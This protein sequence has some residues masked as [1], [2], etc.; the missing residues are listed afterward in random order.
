MNL[1]RKP[2]NVKFSLE[3]KQLINLPSN[4][5]KFSK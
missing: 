1:T 3:E 5:L 2:V 4:R